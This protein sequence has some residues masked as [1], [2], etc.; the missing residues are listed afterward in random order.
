MSLS[1][2]WRRSRV[3]IE[4]SS[5]SSLKISI[6][7]LL[8]QMLRAFLQCRPIQLPL[9]LSSPQITCAVVSFLLPFAFVSIS[10]L[11]CAISITDTLSYIA[12]YTFFHVDNL[13]YLRCY[14]LLRNMRSSSNIVFFFSFTCFVV[15]QFSIFN[16]YI[17]LFK[18]DQEHN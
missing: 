16:L 17:F 12:I 1:W 11:L 13:T 2:T 15:R 9:F 10:M 8:Y 7:Q 14:K 18:N 6:R 5:Y 4:I 3:S